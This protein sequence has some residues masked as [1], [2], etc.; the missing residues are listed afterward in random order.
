MRS[1]RTG[2]LRRGAFLFVVTLTAVCIQLAGVGSLL[3]PLTIFDVP[4]SAQT[5]AADQNDAAKTPDLAP[6]AAFTAGNLV[7]NRIG[8]GTTTLSNAA[9]P[10]ALVEFTPSGTSTGNIINL[11]SFTT[12][13]NNQG[14]FTDS[15]TATSNGQLNRSGDGQF[16]SLIGIDAQVAT[17]SVTGTTSA[18]ANRNVANIDAAGNVVVK[19]R[20]T[21][22]FS[23]DNARGAVTSNGDL[24]WAAG[25]ATPAATNGLRYSDAT[26]S[27]PTTSTQIA[28][29]NLR[30]SAIFA[31]IMFTSTT[32]AISSYGAPSAPPTTATAPTNIVFSSGGIGSGSGSFVFLDRST[33]TG[34]T[35]LNGLDTL[36]LVD[37][38]AIE[39]YEWT[40][41]GWT[42]RGSA[43]ASGTL[44]GL[45]A[46]PNGANVD[47]YATTNLASNN[48]LI[49]IV[50]T[51]GFGGS[52]SGTP[53]TIANAGTNFAFRGVAL[54]PA[55]VAVPDL[56]IGVSGP[57]TGV[58]GTPYDYTITAS[59][60]GSANATG[61]KATF[62]LPSGVTYGSASGTG[63]F[64]CSHSSGL[65][66]CTG[67]SIAAAGSA[68]ITVSVTPT[69]VGSV[70]VPIGAAVVDPDNTITESN[71]TNNTSTAS[72]TTVVDA[73]PNT[74]PTITESSTTPLID[75]PAAGP[76]VLSGVIGDTSDPA[77][78]FG[79][80]FSVNDAETPAG[81][82]NVTAVSSNLTVVPAAGLSLTGGGSSRNLKITPASTGYSNITVTVSDGSLSASYVINYAASVPPSATADTRW[83][84]GRADASTAVAVDADLMFVAD[85]EDQGLRLYERAASG[86]PLANFDVTSNLGLTDI[87]GGIPREVDIEASMRIGSRIYWMAS[88]SNSASGNNRVNR[89]RFFAT[90][91]SG[92]GVSTALTYVGRYEG[93]K[94]D[95][96][97]W[98]NS[99]GH[100]LG[101]GYFGLASSAAPPKIPEEPDGSG[102][103]IE[104]IT[105]SPDGSAMYVCFRAPLEP[106]A[107]RTNA[108]IVPVTNYASLVTANPS[109][110]PAVFGAPFL[111]DLGG[112]GIREIKKSSANEYLILA[113]SPT[114]TWDFAIYE[115]TGNPG[116]VPIR[117]RV[118]FGDQHPEGI[119]EVPAGLSSLSPEAEVTVQ[120]V[121]DNG[122]D[123]YYGDG[124][125]AKELPNDRLKKFRSDK[126][127]VGLAPTAAGVAI[128]GRL[129]N[130]FGDG[131]GAAEIELRSSD[132]TVR[133]ARSGP[134]G[135]F[136]FDDVE[137]GETYV[138]LA[139]SK[140][141]RFPLRFVSVVDEITEVVIVAEP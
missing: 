35:N 44:F 59:N 92:S 93:L 108:L 137:V 8:N 68:T 129:V 74:A 89:S 69:S 140:R 76:G 71:E 62:T 100:G 46:V 104:G 73:A 65:V 98:D 78:L 64:S 110:G 94:A 128:S 133:K 80:D 26:S 55:S 66:T 50:D 1:Q 134:F 56:T 113:G 115:W 96:I 67:A 30:N 77:Q 127:L 116:D 21:D 29:A 60:V 117:R 2:S 15:G 97:A 28:S 22:A 36:Y 53:T 91:V 88:H 51:S 87:S 38:S 141:Y 43:T 102:F 32:T 12:G 101:A 82:L 124:V 25:T 9:F 13:G 138:I 79:V 4:A 48:A 122:D 123:I 95:L 6:A 3:P 41:S 37:G 121:S 11:P 90:D 125:I 7:V 131:V 27:V 42:Q 130:A 10:I 31:G 109:A 18:V 118:N 85:D 49:K 17:A 20:W 75:L 63:G 45:A 114:S 107:T 52:I 72:V 83:H 54:A 139:A 120:L 99:N 106:V 132:G 57:A 126:T 24:V 5:S 135:Y 33:T 16:L 23:G 61:V 84:T 112:R 19:T 40:G 119:V 39:K 70:V 81:S 136:M 14:G 86:L 111:L 34:A 103:N 105:T 58:V 47:I